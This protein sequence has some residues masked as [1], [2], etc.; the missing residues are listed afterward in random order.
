M[1]NTK[2]AATSR[3]TTTLKDQDGT[4]IPGT[5][6]D[7]LTLTFYDKVTNGI[8]N[9]RDDQNILGANNGSVD[10]AGLLTWEMQAA[11]NPIV[12][13]TR[14]RESHVALFKFGWDSGRVA[15]HEAEIWCENLNKVP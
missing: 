9:S 10:A 15:Y 6:L 4:A 14:D 1:L 13:A 7:S 2:E 11:D 3:Y 5:S 8:I 12:D